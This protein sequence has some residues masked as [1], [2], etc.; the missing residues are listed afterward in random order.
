ML[1]LELEI[2]LNSESSLKRCAISK[3][4]GFSQPDV[5]GLRGRIF[6][7]PLPLG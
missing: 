5:S 1:E 4:L 3:N 7:N 2:G 6:P